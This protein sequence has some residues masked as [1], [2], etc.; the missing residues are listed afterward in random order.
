MEDSQ[1]GYDREHIAEA[2]DQA[3]ILTM[4]HI[5]DRAGLTATAYLALTRLN[6]EGP[7]RLTALAAAEGLSQP[8]MTQLIQRLERQGLTTRVNDPED[9]RATLVYVTDAGR[10]LLAQQKQDRRDRLAQLLATLPPED[11]ASLSLATHVALP[12]IRE[13][14]RNATTPAPSTTT[15]PSGPHAG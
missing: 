9:G 8:S 11:Q 5:L 12:I 10:A 3:T 7:T 14:I 13:L 15:V 1:H 6:R 2:L 4:R